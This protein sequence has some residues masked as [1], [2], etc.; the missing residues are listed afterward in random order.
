MFTNAD[1]FVE[2]VVGLVL[3]YLVGWYYEWATAQHRANR[4]K[5]RQESNALRIAIANGGLGEFED[6]ELL[7]QIW[8]DLPLRL[9]DVCELTQR[10]AQSAKLRDFEIVRNVRRVSQRTIAAVLQRAAKQN[11]DQFLYTTALTLTVLAEQVR[12]LERRKGFLSVT[13]VCDRMVTLAEE[14]RSGARTGNIR[15]DADPVGAICR[16][17]THLNTHIVALQT[18]AQAPNRPGR[19]RPEQPGR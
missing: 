1:P 15:D 11:D 5:Q 14:V 8:L 12:R 6:H 7:G 3:L 16:A 10:A 2:F 9:Q 13:T 19:P 18:R 4:E 17:F